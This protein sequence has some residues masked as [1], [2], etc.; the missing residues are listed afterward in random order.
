MADTTRPGYVNKN[1]QTVLR[2]TDIPGNDHLQV[3]HVLQCGKC[4]S[5]YGANGSDIW[6]RRCPKC[7]GGKPGL[8]TSR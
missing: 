8:P 4:E 5:E 7:G 2:R 6:Q 3:V 1:G